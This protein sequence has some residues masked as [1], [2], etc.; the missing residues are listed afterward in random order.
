MHIYDLIKRS[1]RSIGSAKARTLLTALAIGVGT[2]SLTLTLAASN[3]TQN[4]VEQ[5]I[6]DNFNPAELLVANDDRILGAGGDFSEPLEYDPSFGD[7]SSTAGAAIQVKRITEED[8]DKISGVGSVNNIRKDIAINLQYI[9]KDE[10]DKYIATVAPFDEY[11]EPNVLA[12]SID[13]PLK[14][15]SILLPEAWLDSL[16]FDSPEDAIGKEL[17]L[18]MRP[19][20]DQLRKSQEEELQSLA[21]QLE[22]LAEPQMIPG[23]GMDLSIDEDDIDI[24]TDEQDIEGPNFTYKVSAVLE[25]QNAVQPGTELYLYI[26]D[27]EALR[28]NDIATEGTDNFRA[29]NFIYAEIEDGEDEE[30]I[31]QAQEEIEELG[32]T[33]LSVQD[34]QEFLNQIISV[35]QGIVVAFGVIAI[36][37]SIFGIINTM[38]ISVLQRTR[39]IGLLKALGMRSRDV[40]RLFRFEAAWIGFLGATIGS[41]LA[42][43]A[44]ITLNPWISEQLELGEGNYLLMFEAIEIVLLILV[45]MAVSILAGWLPSRKAAKLDPIE[46][47][48]VE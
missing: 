44:G 40:G 29:Y 11:V 12:G 42:V 14:D 36:I 19:T 21:E 4:F 9:T 34:T 15:D 28:L 17:K 25:R 23:Q 37:A 30:N 7:A 1:G 48:R 3:G 20:P 27:N 45:L 8:I 38:Y 22:G 2:F 41:V 32:Y 31:K 13:S 35:L 43:A 16:G 46:A 26:S 33:A 47:L 24:G 10:E 39:E 18:V 5:I 6:Q